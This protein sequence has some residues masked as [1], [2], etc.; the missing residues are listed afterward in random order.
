MITPAAMQ[1]IH[2]GKNVPIT[3]IWGALE[4]ELQ[5]I[6]ARQSNQVFP[7]L[8]TTFLLLCLQGVFVEG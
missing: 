1:N 8:R 5:P 4:Q 3:S 6:T 7:A 2:A